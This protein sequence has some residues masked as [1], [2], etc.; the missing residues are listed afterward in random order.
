MNTPNCPTPRTA[1]CTAAAARANRAIRTPRAHLSRAPA[2][3]SLAALA[4]LTLLATGCS[5]PPPTV[6][7]A[8][9]GTSTST[10]GGLVGTAPAPSTSA[11][12]LTLPAVNVSD[13]DI[14]E[15]V[16]TALQQRDA[17]KG[18]A[19]TVVTTKGDVRLS[20]M[21]DTQAQVD[22]VLA[23]ARAAEGAH[24]VHDELTVKK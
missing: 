14:T 10:G 7:G 16:T 17:L 23:I 22:E 12:G 20:G 11:S 21:V 9:T 13:V 2:A 6:D 4:L 3:G 1:A 15:H 5:K 24:T 19:I 18:F 8:S